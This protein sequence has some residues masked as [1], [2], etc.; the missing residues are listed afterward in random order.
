M[1]YLKA[2]NTKRGDWGTIKKTLVRRAAAGA[3]QMAAA[4]GP[5]PVAAGGQR[6]PAASGH[7]SAGRPGRIC[8]SFS[9][10]GMESSNA[11]FLS[12][13]RLWPVVAKQPGSTRD[14]GSPR[15]ALGP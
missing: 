12:H 6:Q 15:R 4:G 3:R 10:F 1:K 14:Q 11:R 8:A 5:R 9:P 2:K 13:I 7:Q